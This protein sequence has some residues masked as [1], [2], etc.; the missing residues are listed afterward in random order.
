MYNKAMDWTVLLVSFW[1]WGMVFISYFMIPQLLKLRNMGFQ[2]NDKS[3]WFAAVTIVMLWPIHGLI[4]IIGSI[5][6]LLVK[7]R[8]VK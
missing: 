4:A 6:T 1:I 7:S 8:A 3:Y 5:I 2:A